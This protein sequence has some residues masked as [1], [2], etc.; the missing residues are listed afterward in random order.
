MAK[1]STRLEALHDTFKENN[2]SPENIVK[3][4]SL[5]RQ[6]KKYADSVQDYRHPSY[7]K[8]LLGD[9]IMI[10][11]FAILGNANEWGEIESFA[12]KKEAWLRKYLELPYGIPTDDTYRI[13]IGNINTDYFFQVTVGL[14]L[15]TVDGI[16]EASGKEQALH[17]KSIVSVDG[18]VSCGS[19]RKNHMDGEEKALQTLNVFSNDY[20]MCLAQKFIG[21]KTNEI[22]AA[23]EILRLMDLKDT[24]VT[25]DAMNCQKETAAAVIGRKGDYVLALKGNQ[26]LFYEEV[27]AFFDAECK[28]ELRKRKGCYQKTVEPEHGGIAT[29]EY[30]IT[31]DIGWY[32]ERKQWKG[33]KSFGMVHKKIEKPDGSREK[34]CRYYIC[35]IG[36]NVEEFERAARGHWGVENNLHRQMDFTFKDDKNTSMA[37]TG[38]KNLQIMKKIVL[39]I[40]GLVKESY[41]IS[42]KRI[43]YEL[44]L[45]YE[46]G[47]EKMLSMLDIDSIKKALYSTRKSPLK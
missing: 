38:A 46:N 32:S 13:V 41:K 8:H 45:D 18:K 1:K 36:E 31:E 43:R 6:I 44:S 17:E 26:P 4:D 21:E 9:I 23:Q 40:L 3:N 22:P 33:L 34:E 27:M 24:I 16:L 25:A 30:Y 35:S 20:G 5:I 15:H 14:L 7:V 12:K 2:I 39:S 29:R 42:M 28:G 19:G 37:R 47:V 10:V 11:F